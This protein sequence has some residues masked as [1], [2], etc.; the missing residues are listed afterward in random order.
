MVRWKK[1]VDSPAIR[2]SSQKYE[3]HRC[4]T[5]TRVEQLRGRELHSNIEG[6]RGPKVQGKHIELRYKQAGIIKENIYG[7]TRARASRRVW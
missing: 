3:N 7:I 6:A 2:K 5:L 1:N 4:P